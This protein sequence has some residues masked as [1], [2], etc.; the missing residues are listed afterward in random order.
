MLEWLVCSKHEQQQAVHMMLAVLLA[1]GAYLV[2][3]FASLACSS[4]VAVK[5]VTQ[6]HCYTISC[7][8]VSVYSISIC[9]L[10]AVPYIERGTFSETP[11]YSRILRR[12]TRICSKLIA[13]RAHSFTVCFSCM[14]AV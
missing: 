5:H 8:I 11:T 10:I 14:F 3:R 9:V 2:T 12:I 6:Y 13:V 1:A 7:Y 4:T